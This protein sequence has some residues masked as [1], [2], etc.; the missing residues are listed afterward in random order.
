PFQSG[1]AQFLGRISFTLYL[2]HIP[3]LCSLG[4]WL[5]IH[6]S[7]VGYLGTALIGMPISVMACLLLS[8]IAT[9]AVDGLGIRS[10]RFVGAKLDGVIGLLMPV[11]VATAGEGS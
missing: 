5:I 9:P 7:S 1:Y 11:R 3:L 10:S 8:A 6:L 2:M 4:A